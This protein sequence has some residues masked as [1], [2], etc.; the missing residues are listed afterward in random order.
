MIEH[1]IRIILF[2]I[3]MYLFSHVLAFLFLP[4]GLLIVVMDQKKAPQ[5]K[6]LY[7]SM[8]FW[9]V[10]KRV[11]TIGEEKIDKEQNYLVVANYPSFYAGFALMSVFPKASIVAHAFISKIPILGHTLKQVGAIFVDPKKTKRTKGAIDEVFKDT[12]YNNDMIIF[13]EGQ[14][15]P[16]GRIKRFRRGFVYILR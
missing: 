4:I 3:S 13:P 8:L 6:K 5:L 16:D 14:R 11:N 15:T 7:T 12:E 2:T 10:G 1:R 9:I